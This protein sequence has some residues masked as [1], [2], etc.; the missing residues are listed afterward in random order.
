MKG[1]N[2]HCDVLVVGGGMSGIFAALKAKEQGADVLLTDK[3][4]VGRSGATIWSSMFTAFSPAW[5]HDLKDGWDS[6][7]MLLKE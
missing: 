6:W 1:K 4:Y 3:N 7:M 5:G 2:L